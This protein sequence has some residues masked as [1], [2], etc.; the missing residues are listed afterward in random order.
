[1]RRHHNKPGKPGRRRAL[2]LLAA[3]GPAGCPAGTLA[4][5]GY[6]AATAQGRA[7]LAKAMA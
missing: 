3:A 5:A 7:L 1:M 6:A 4:A 2:E